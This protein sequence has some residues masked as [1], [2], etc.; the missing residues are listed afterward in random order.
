[1]RAFGSWLSD[2]L[3]ILLYVA[4]LAVL[5]VGC[6]FFGLSDRRAW[7]EQRLA[8]ARGDQAG[9]LAAIEDH[10]RQL[11]DDDDYQAIQQYRRSYQRATGKDID[12]P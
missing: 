10:Q 1:M 11:S 3:G 12:L 2:N 8:C 4:F 5:V 9:C 6:L 7:Q